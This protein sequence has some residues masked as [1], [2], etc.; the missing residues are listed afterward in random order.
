M[1]TKIN[2]GDKVLCVNPAGNLEKN[3]VYIIS[4]INGLNCFRLNHVYSWWS[5][6]RFVSLNSL[7]SKS[8]IINFINKLEN[9]LNYG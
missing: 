3:K 8:D 7:Y 6:N 4:D 5:A 2:I 9:K 1:K